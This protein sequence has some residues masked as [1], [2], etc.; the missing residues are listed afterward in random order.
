MVCRFC[1]PFVVV[2]CN[3][4][5]PNRPRQIE[6]DDSNTDTQSFRF[7]SNPIQALYSIKTKTFSFLL[8]NA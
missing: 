8:R 2:I 7:S 4:L 3:F 6:I 5:I 1:S